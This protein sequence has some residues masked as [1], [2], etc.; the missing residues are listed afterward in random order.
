LLVEGYEV[1]VPMIVPT[2]MRNQR[3]GRAVL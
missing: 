3:R 2:C 1:K